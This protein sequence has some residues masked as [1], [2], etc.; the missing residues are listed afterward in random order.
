MRYPKLHITGNLIKERTQFQCRCLG[1]WRYHVSLAFRF[2]RCLS[3]VVFRFALLTGQPPF[4]GETVKKTYRNIRALK[5][6]WPDSTTQ[7]THEGKREKDMDNSLSISSAAKS[8]IA[9]IL[10]AD[11]CMICFCCVCSSWRVWTAA[12]PTI[13]QIRSDAFFSA[14]SVP[15][16]LPASLASLCQ[17]TQSQQST[18]IDLTHGT[19]SEQKVK[20]SSTLWP[21]FA[22]PKPR[23]PTKS[24]TTTSNTM[25]D[26]AADRDGVS[27]KETKKEQPQTQAHSTTG[28]VDSKDN[29]KR[30][31]E[32]ATSAQTQNKGNG[33]ET[34]NKD[35]DNNDN[36][37]NKQ[38]K[39]ARPLESISE[40]DAEAKSTNANTN[41]KTTN[42]DTIAMSVDTHA[43]TAMA[44]DIVVDVQHSTSNSQSQGCD[45]VFVVRWLDASDKFGLFYRLSN[46]DVGVYSCPSSCL[47]FVS[48]SFRC[49]ISWQRQGLARC[50]W[51]RLAACSWWFV[52]L[53]FSLFELCLCSSAF[54]D[55][56]RV[57]FFDCISDQ[58]RIGEET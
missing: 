47:L 10:V 13:A 57:V 28:S 48:H 23:A 27:S 31:R 42:A 5:Y 8:L 41:T 11:P 38:R 55:Q 20:P 3:C 33:K 15:G 9:R 4:E 49:T 43:H 16:S 51:T 30:K 37:N 45:L 18:P 14:C 34:A 54:G 44:V 32:H 58:R 1:Y 17:Q 22:V 53:C 21:I 56:N 25:K 35:K 46:D 19:T 26:T 39:K 2:V 24:Q 50:Q 36:D 40:M 29:R 12:R 52:C 6:A 7:S